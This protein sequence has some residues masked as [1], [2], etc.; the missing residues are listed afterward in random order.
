MGR[1]LGLGL[2]YSEAKARHMNEDTVEG[3]ETAAAICATLEAMVDAGRL[4]RTVLPLTRAILNTVCR[5][6]PLE[7][8]WDRF[9]VQ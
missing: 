3:A 8:P 4:D 1:W 2:S 9:F 6:A 7:I 5:D